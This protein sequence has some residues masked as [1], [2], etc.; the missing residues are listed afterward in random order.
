METGR[1]VC[2]SCGTAVGGSARRCT[3]CGSELV[4]TS[5]FKCGLLAPGSGFEGDRC[6]RCELQRSSPDPGKQSLAKLLLLRCADFT[7]GYGCML[8]IV[9]AVG[10][11]LVGS[12]ALLYRSAGMACL[13]VAVSAL[14]WAVID[15]VRAARM[16]QSR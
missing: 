9:I 16:N 10:V 13:G 3:Q 1:Y 15:T 8:L 11:V 4:A 2:C 6:P 7:V 5:C 12:D 14:L